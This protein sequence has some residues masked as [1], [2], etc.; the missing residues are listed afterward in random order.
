MT[1]MKASDFV[2]EHEGRF[3]VAYW[4]EKAARYEGSLTTEI[5]KKSGCSGFF[6]R[7]KAGLPG[8]GGYS[9]AHRRSAL[10]RARD[11][12]EFSIGSR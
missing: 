10:A 12:Y 5:A 8:A 9:Y 6:C 3:Y 2:V 7:S 1:N 11:C 4:N